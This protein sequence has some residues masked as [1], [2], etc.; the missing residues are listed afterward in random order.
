MIIPG[1]HTKYN[2]QMLTVN[3]YL[4]S[5]KV[6]RKRMKKKN[7]NENTN[8]PKSN[9]VNSSTINKLLLIESTLKRK[10]TKIASF[11]YLSKKLV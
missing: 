10:E 3:G 11:W 7:T 2:N 9:S 5:K 4:N 8:S 1:S 6:I